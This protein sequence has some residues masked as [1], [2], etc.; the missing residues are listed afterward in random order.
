MVNPSVCFLSVPRSDYSAVEP[1]QIH[2]FFFFFCFDLFFVKTVS[3]PGI[4]VW[5]CVFHSATQTSVGRGVGGA[6]RWG[7]TNKNMAPV[8]PQWEKECAGWQA[9]S[10]RPF[11]SAGAG[12]EIQ[13]AKYLQYWDLSVCL[14]WIVQWWDDVNLLCHLWVFNRAGKRPELATDLAYDKLSKYFNP[15]LS[16][17][18]KPVKISSEN[19]IELFQCII[20]LYWADSEEM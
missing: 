19:E 5:S 20:A 14:L 18:T 15:P 6:W 11:T 2:F 9:I 16:T 7:H 12:Q 8:G 3:W 1:L 13:I 4:I 17:E 10:A